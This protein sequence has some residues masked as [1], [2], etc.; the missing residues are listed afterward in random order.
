VLF[1]DPY[2]IPVV[3]MDEQAKSDVK[4]LIDRIRKE[5]EERD[6]AYHEVMLAHLKVLA[7]PRHEAQVAQGRVRA[8]RGRTSGIPSWPNCVT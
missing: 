1:N 3:I 6:L 8:G 4:G 2:G 5:H 7:G